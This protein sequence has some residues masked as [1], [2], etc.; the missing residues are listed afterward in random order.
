M[1]KNNEIK[2][3]KYDIKSQLAYITNICE[4]FEFDGDTLISLIFA[5]WICTFQTGYVKKNLSF[6]EMFVSYLSAAHRTQKQLMELKKCL[7]KK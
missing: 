4:Q 1:S 3:P 2:I 5:D 7:E 6:Q